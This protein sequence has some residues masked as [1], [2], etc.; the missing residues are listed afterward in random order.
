MREFRRILEL[1]VLLGMSSSELR[2]TNCSRWS[3]STTTGRLARVN[4]SRRRERTPSSSGMSHSFAAC[5]L[6]SVAAMG[7]SPRRCRPRRRRPT[8]QARL[9]NSRLAHSLTSWER[10]AAGEPRDSG[11]T[12]NGCAFVQ[13]GAHEP[14]EGGE[15]VL[16][17]RTLDTRQTGQRGGGGLSFVCEGGSTK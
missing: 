16:F 9:R 5:Q 4:S 8:R 10:Q 17:Q 14:V 13:F 1:H 3:S 12:R 2:S 6:D 15:R 7:F 11:T